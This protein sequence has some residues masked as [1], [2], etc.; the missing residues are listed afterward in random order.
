MV[1]VDLTVALEP[2]GEVL[3][4]EADRARCWASSRDQTASKF[5]IPG[6][7][8]PI[9]SG[10]AVAF[11]VERGR[12]ECP[13]AR[14]TRDVLETEAVQEF[15]IQMLGAHIGVVAATFRHDVG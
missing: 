8:R 5:N 12:H 7:R 10:V 15:L 1:S 13:G 4:C 6:P 11:E 2:L 14:V 3:G 9:S